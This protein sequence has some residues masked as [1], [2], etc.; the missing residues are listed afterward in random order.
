LGRNRSNAKS[1][2]KIGLASRKICDKLA[3]K[4]RLTSAISLEANAN[5]DVAI[6]RPVLPERARMWVFA[7]PASAFFSDRTCLHYSV[8]SCVSRRRD[9]RQSD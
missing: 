3:V 4:G 6:A 7:P 9:R 8:E 2:E 5:I 1:P